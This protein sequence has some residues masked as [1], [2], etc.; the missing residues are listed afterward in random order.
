MSVTTTAKHLVSTG[1]AAGELGITISLVRRYIRE[2]RLPAMRIGERSWA[3]ARKD[4][5]R[6]KAERKANRRN[7]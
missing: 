3:I 7:D 5:E 1:E 4:L 6:F 2:H